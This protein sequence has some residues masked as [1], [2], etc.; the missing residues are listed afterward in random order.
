MKDQPIRLLVFD[1]WIRLRTL[2]TLK[3]A[4]QAHGSVESIKRPFDEQLPA[5]TLGSQRLVQQSQIVGIDTELASG[6]DF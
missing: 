1:L 6:F 3:L 2:T 5:N 4:V